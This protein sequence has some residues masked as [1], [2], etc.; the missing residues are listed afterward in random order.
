M[1][2]S[3]Y[4]CEQFKLI[5]KLSDVTDPFKNPDALISYSEVFDEY[6]LII[7]DGGESS[8]LI[9]FCPWC[10]KKLPSSKRE[11]WFDELETLGFSSPFTEEL[12][13]EYD[14]S[15]WW[16]KKEK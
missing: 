15:E 3:D 1:I 14:S 5:L 8:V 4:C 11:L 7:H 13:K 9:E 2:K 10:G 6:G 16:Q 12:P